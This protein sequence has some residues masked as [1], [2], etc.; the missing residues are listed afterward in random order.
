MIHD[1][2]SGTVVVDYSTQSIFETEEAM[3]ETK[4][5]IH[6]DKVENTPA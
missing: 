3:I 1:L 6:A 4:K 5:R 2:M